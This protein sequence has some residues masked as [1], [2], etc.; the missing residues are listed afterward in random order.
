[1]RNANETGQERR[2]DGDAIVVNM[3]WEASVDLDLAGL[4]VPV[5]GDRAS[6]V[7]YGNRGTRCEAPFAH[8]ALDHQGGG[9]RKQ[10]REHLVITNLDAQEQ[11]FLFGWDHDAIAGGPA[12]EVDA[13]IREWVVTMM[14]RYNM[15][16]VCHGAFDHHHNLTLVGAITNRVFVDIG[17]SARVTAQSELL[18]VIKSLV[19]VPVEVAA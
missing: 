1:M 14:D 5:N 7:Y 12:T 19:D 13:G 15:R 16:I 18:P 3:A 10:R 4:C 17:K 9:R 8:L 2:L 11:I 6:L